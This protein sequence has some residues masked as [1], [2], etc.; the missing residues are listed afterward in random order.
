MSLLLIPRWN[1]RHV[2]PRIH[3]THPAYR[4][5]SCFLEQVCFL[6]TLKSRSAFRF[7]FFANRLKEG[8]NFV[9]RW[10]WTETLRE[11]TETFLPC[12]KKSSRLPFTYFFFFL[13]HYL[14]L[15]RRITNYVKYNHDTSFL[16]K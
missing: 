11:S 7:R 8:V 3:G 4:I 12:F 9:R 16:Y 14:R 1:L 5:T 6:C 13:L 2:D 10:N 15:E